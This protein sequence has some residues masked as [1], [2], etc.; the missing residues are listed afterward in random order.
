MENQEQK[1]ANRKSALVDVIIAAL[2]VGFLIAKWILARY[3]N[4]YS[5]CCG[6]AFNMTFS[7][8]GLRQAIREKRNKNIK[9]LYFITAGLFVIAAVLDIIKIMG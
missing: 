7:V 8:F 3:N 1:K 5:D 4:M 2:L 6:V 9:V